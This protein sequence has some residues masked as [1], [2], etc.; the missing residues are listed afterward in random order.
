[1]RK[2]T[3]VQP[4]CDITKSV[5]DSWHEVYFVWWLEEAKKAEI[6]LHYKRIDEQVELIPDVSI[7]YYKKMKKVDDKLVT[8]KLLSNVKFKHDF[9]IIWNPK[10]KNLVFD[11]YTKDIERNGYLLDSVID[12][13][14]LYLKSFNYISERNVYPVSYY[15]VKNPFN[16]QG[17]RSYFSI[18]QRLV[19]HTRERV[20]QEILYKELFKYTFTPARFL[21]T[22]SGKSNRGLKQVPPMTT[23]TVNAYMKEL[24]E[25]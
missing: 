16:F 18:R 1:M 7:S 21:K 5:Y 4:Y 20:V 8:T 17:M 3:T 10:Y 9:T 11:Y 14:P 2:K 12:R 15:D 22:D 24:K 23:R 19:H 13:R 6:V 25:L